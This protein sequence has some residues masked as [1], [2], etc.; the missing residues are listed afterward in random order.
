MSRLT[1]LADAVVA[2]LNAA[3]GGTFSTAFEASR[4][5]LP[6]VTNADEIESVRVLVSPAGV[7]SVETR[8]RKLT[9]HRLRVTVGVQQKLGDD[10]EAEV[11]ALGTLVDEIVDYLIGR[12]A[13]GATFVE[14]ANSPF[15][16]EKHLVENRVFTSLIVVTYSALVAADR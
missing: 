14:L 9:A 10:E 6:R 8:T 12:D 15:C 1:D 7:P 4:S 3:P 13:G 5:V 16:S 11:A 2:A